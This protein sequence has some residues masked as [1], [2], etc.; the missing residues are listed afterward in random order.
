MSSHLR[1][2]HDLRDEARVYINRGEVEK[3]RAALYQAAG[4]TIA[5][6]ED[7]NAA[8]KDLR[9]VLA[10]LGDLRSALTVD[11]YAGGESSQAELIK[12]ERVPHIDRAR[13]YLAWADR[14]NQPDQAKK[15]YRKAADEYESEHLVAQAA[16]AAERGGDFARART[17]WSRLSQVLSATGSELYAAGLARFNLARMSKQ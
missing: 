5:R 17:L 6:E 2:L 9:D 14:Q 1:P 7:Y 15:L 8:V 13:T 3:A 4:Q 16:I 12:S 10:R 11:W